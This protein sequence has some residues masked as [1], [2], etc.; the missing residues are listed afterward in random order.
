[1]TKLANITRFFLQLDRVH[2]A[3]TGSETVV[4][5][6]TQSGILAE[7]RL[8]QETAHLAMLAVD[9]GN[10]VIQVD[11]Q[12]QPESATYGAY[13]LHSPDEMVPQRPAFNGHLLVSD[14]YLLGNG[15]RGYSPVLMRFLSPDSLS[16]F[17]EGGLSCY[18]YCASDP[19]NFSDPSGHMMRSRSPSPTGRMSPATQDRIV[20]EVLNSQPAWS[21]GGG[22][23]RRTSIEIQEKIV[24]EALNSQPGWRS[25]AQTNSQR[26]LPLNDAPTQ[27]ITGIAS[28]AE[29]GVTG[30]LRVGF[31]KYSRKPI[32]SQEV[33]SLK[34]WNTQNYQLLS[35]L[36]LEESR[37]V[38][39]AVINALELGTNPQQSIR[40]LNYGVEPPRVRAL[41]QV[42]K[43]KLSR[44]R[45]GR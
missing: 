39:S 13:G 9:S 24:Q 12:A 35:P 8:E 17:A 37:I 45:A 44:I 6:R 1:M 30:R 18:A 42:V 28:V 25:Q 38:R 34:K 14:L 33:S 32:T 10:S 7:R 31:Y 27:Q 40:D 23:G 2:I 22:N 41:V 20:L 5:I 11:S 29:L 16:P 21:T 15:Y 36:N 19:I 43:Q 4:C 26:S 3:L